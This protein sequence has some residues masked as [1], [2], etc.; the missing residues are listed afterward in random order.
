MVA[1]SLIHYLEPDRLPYSRLSVSGVD[2]NS[3]TYQLPSPIESQEIEDFV[4]YYM[5]QQFLP[6][7]YKTC[8]NY[9]YNC[10]HNF[11]GTLNEILNSLYKHHPV[12]VSMS[13]HQ[14]LFLEVLETYSDHYVIGIYDPNEAEEQ[15]LTL[16]KDAYAVDDDPKIHISYGENNYIRNYILSDDLDLIDVRNY[17][18]ITPDYE[19][20]TDYTDGHIIIDADND[21]G[22]IFGHQYYY[23]TENGKLCEK[24]SNVKILKSSNA[25]N[26]D[27]SNN[28]IELVFPKP[29]S[30]EDA[31]LELTSS[32]VND[33]SML[34]NDTM[35]SVST[36]GPTR[37]TYNEQARTI[38]VTSST[39]TGVSLLLTQNNPSEAWPW[40]TFAVDVPQ[41]TTLHI[42]LTGD[43]LKISG[44][45]LSG[46]TY[47]TENMT[48]DVVSGGD[49][50]DGM[51]NVTIVNKNGSN[52]NTTDIKT[53]D[54]V[55]P[56]EL[57]VSV[58]GG[59]II[60][61]NDDAFAESLTTHTAKQGDK[62]T[63]MADT[64]DKFN[65]WT[66]NE[67]DVELDDATAPTT[68]FTMNEKSVR[69][70]AEYQNSSTD[71]TPTPTPG[72]NSSSGSGGGGGGGAAVL[73][74]V[75]AAA[76][77][78]AG[79][80]M[81]S[82]VEIKGRVV[83]ADQAAVPGAKISLLREGK[84]V[85][86]T[87]ADENGN[88]SL[89]AKRGSYELTAAYT[90]ADGQLIYKTIDIKAPVKDLTMTF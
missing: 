31:V 72:G 63:I 1:I 23:R 16:Y 2:D 14:I 49:I 74:G 22:F 79:V 40:D 80:F 84:V 47:A 10:E 64:T 86:Q 76:A 52:G 45:Y 18:D 29:S 41:S 66:V 43:S 75:G 6:T 48:D 55:E 81:M 90:N 78:T 15:R 25:L 50:P 46:A 60:Q 87:T 89:K 39:P 53:P 51:D 69:I 68:T 34:L 36:D 7:Y 82:P 59:T 57:T 61:I 38:D 85:A 35:L 77:I 21:F 54:P 56:A 12:F 73:I 5:M 24:N 13:N 19:T 42:E 20:Q 88:F 71:P 65:G 32:G 27:S 30:S 11:E 44:D 83:L 33:A 26:E 28:L 62:I 70:T 4:N 17:F 3:L 8:S 9:L 58:S 67:G 37:L